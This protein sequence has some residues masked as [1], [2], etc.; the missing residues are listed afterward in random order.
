MAGRREVILF[1]AL[2]LFAG[3]YVRTASKTENNIRD[4][5]DMA[6]S[7][8][9]KEDSASD[10]NPSTKDLV[11]SLADGGTKNPSSVV[12]TIENKNPGNT[13]TLLK[14]DS[15]FDPTALN[16]GVFKIHDA[17]TGKE[18]A[19]PR[20]RVS[21]MLPPS[22]EDL[23]ELLPRSSVSAGVELKLPWI[24]A[25]ER[26][27]QVQVE[28]QWRAVWPRSKA[29]VHDEELHAMSG[30]DVLKGRFQSQQVLQLEL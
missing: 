12:V 21:R 9:S 17:A 5:G 6:T 20:I 1:I 14:W 26:K 11:V 22:H 19:S 27:V 7:D 4:S 23:V 8:E 10:R 3:L 29:Q 18:I 25:D 30:D 24:P 28:G 15:P 13:L 16:S 2:I